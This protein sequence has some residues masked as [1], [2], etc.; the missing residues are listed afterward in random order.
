MAT[1]IDIDKLRSNLD[2]M[3]KKYEAET[4]RA[5]WDDNQGGARYSSGV[6]QGI[7]L[8][9]MEIIRAEKESLTKKK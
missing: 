3:A 4:Q 2:E 5:N 8:S 9:I 1:K 6:A 7:R